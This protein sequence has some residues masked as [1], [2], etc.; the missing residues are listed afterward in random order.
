MCVLRASTL[1]RLYGAIRR[2]RIK[3]IINDT[4]EVAMQAYPLPGNL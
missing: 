1:M 2:A 3:E 4:L